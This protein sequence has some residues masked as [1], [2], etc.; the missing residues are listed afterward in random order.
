MISLFYAFEKNGLSLIQDV[1]ES[2]FRNMRNSSTNTGFRKTLHAF[3][4]LE[5][6]GEEKLMRYISNPK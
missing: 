2:A 1:R 6:F 5:Q 3:K 4:L